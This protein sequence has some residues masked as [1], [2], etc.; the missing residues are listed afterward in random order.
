[1]LDVETA[2]S[3]VGDYYV[4]KFGKPGANSKHSDEVVRKLTRGI[5]FLSK[6]GVRVAR[7]YQQ[8]VEVTDEQMQ[9]LDDLMVNRR[10]AI[11]G[12]AGSGKTLIAQEFAKRLPKSNMSSSKHDHRNWNNADRNGKREVNDAGSESKT[13]RGD[14]DF[15]QHHSAVAAN[16]EGSRAAR[17]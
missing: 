1:M 2:V 3:T 5:G 15:R 11:K 4:R 6:V 16:R 10:I 9:V 7:D 12:F 8:L 17:N 13:R 14:F